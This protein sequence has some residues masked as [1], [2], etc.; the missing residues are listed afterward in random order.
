MVSR[1]EA[2]RDRSKAMEGQRREEN[3]RREIS[4]MVDEEVPNRFYCLKYLRK[5]DL[6]FRW[7]KRYR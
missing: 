7:T 3:L 6:G 5:L 4:Q 1:E 2:S